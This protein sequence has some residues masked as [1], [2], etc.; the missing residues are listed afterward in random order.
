[1]VLPSGGQIAISD[2]RNEFGDTPGEDGLN[3]YYR[4]AGYVPDN[5]NNVPTSGQIAL[6][7]FHSGANGYYVTVGQSNPFSGLKNI[8]RTSVAHLL[9]FLMTGTFSIK[10]SILRKEQAVF[11]RLIS[12]L[13]GDTVL[14]IRDTCGNRRCG[15]NGFSSCQRSKRGKSRQSRS[16]LSVTRQTRRK[17]NIGRQRTSAKRFWKIP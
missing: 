7:N 1:M 3:E 9:L 15:N 4:G 17:R 8:Y 13:S 10:S 2:L 11:G 16:S 12:R 5:N 6:S 14:I